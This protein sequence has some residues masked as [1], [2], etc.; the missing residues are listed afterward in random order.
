MDLETWRPS[1]LIEEDSIREFDECLAQLLVGQEL[2]L[3][4]ERTIN[5]AEVCNNELNEGLA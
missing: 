4:Q 2:R 1:I 3:A 5:Q